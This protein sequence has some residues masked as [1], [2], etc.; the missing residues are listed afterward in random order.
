MVSWN[1]ESFVILVVGDIVNRN[2]HVLISL[3]VVCENTDIHIPENIMNGEEDFGDDINTEK[4][5]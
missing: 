4:D 1:N 5:V 2:K 3:V